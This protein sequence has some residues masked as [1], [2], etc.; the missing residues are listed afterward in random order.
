MAATVTTVSGPNVL[1]PKLKCAVYQIAM[2]SSYPADGEAIDL[3]ADFT[4]VYAASIGGNDTTA[5][6]GYKF[7]AI[8]PSP[9]TAVT[10]S[11]V[12]ITA[13][14]DPADGGAAEVLAE[15]T[16]TEDLE[17]VGQLSLVVFGY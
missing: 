13:F 8:L 6:N 10:A 5:D 15:V 3:S 9:T 17:S 4:Y 14:W 2:D 1:A 11:N 7:D 16:A 12:L